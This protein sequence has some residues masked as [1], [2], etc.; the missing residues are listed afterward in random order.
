M[1]RIIR[2]DNPSYKKI[3]YSDYVGET[4]KEILKLKKEIIKKIPKENIVGLC[5]THG[6]AM[7]YLEN[8]KS[9][10]LDEVREYVVMSVKGLL[11]EGFALDKCAHVVNKEYPTC[12]NNN[13]LLFLPLI[14]IDNMEY[15]QRKKYISNLEKLGYI[16]LPPFFAEKTENEI[17]K[18]FENNKF[19]SLEEET[20]EK[21][22]TV[23]VSKIYSL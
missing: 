13:I 22:S 7:G 21:V 1:E 23:K 11:V 10:M 3:D 16:E 6:F 20:P 18:L 17:I 4:K 14:C 15:E 2:L 12:S 8:D 9:E 19:K 5:C